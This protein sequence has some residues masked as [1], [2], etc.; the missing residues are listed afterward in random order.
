MK[1]SLSGAASEN[2]IGRGHAGRVYRV[3]GENGGDLAE[4]VFD[5]IRTAQLWYSISRWR[6]HPY[7]AEYRD[8]A[9]RSAFELRRVAHRVSKYFDTG[10]EVNDALEINKDGSG[11]YSPFIADGRPYSTG[12][13]A[14]RKALNRTERIFQAIGLPVWSFG[15]SF[16]RERCRR[17]N[18]LVQTDGR[19]RIV[20][21]ESGWPN[22]TFESFFGFDDVDVV[23]FQEF[24]DKRA[25]KLNT[26]L[27]EIEYNKLLESWEKYKICNQYWRQE[28]HAPVELI[29]TLFQALSRPVLEK[30]AGELVKEGIISQDQL[31]ELKKMIIRN[32]GKLKDIAPHVVVHSVL[33]GLIPIPFMGM[34]SRAGYTGLMRLVS[35]LNKK[36]NLIAGKQNK[37]SEIHT[38]RVVILTMIP[39]YA[40]P[41]DFFAYI[42][43]ILDRDPFSYLLVDTIL[44]EVFGQ[45]LASFMQNFGA[46]KPGSFINDRVLQKI[47][48]DVA[49]RLENTLDRLMAFL[50]SEM[51]VEKGKAAV[52]KGMETGRS[53][54][55]KLVL[56]RDFL[57][58]AIISI[59]EKH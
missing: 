21:Y 48:P 50:L 5:P 14:V 38:L 39:I 53:A 42:S 34:F 43:S 52:K 44:H 46:S 31:P 58:Q 1:E 54:D 45:D 41:F 30:R 25:D 56:T 33:T 32:Q 28:E 40:P 35:N 4:K 20:D 9:I 29:H 2:L 23:R 49:K 22:S 10:A 55:E 8:I 12:D 19:A 27:G 59:E 15:G 47:N 18:V 13:I 7:G 6:E 16:F 24:L 26:S 51:L 11:F 57:D 3:R 36:Y 37:T 17:S